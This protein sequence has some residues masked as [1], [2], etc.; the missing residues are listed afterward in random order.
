MNRTSLFF[1]SV[2]LTLEGCALAE[3]NRC[4]TARPSIILPDQRLALAHIN[5]GSAGRELAEAVFAGNVDA[6]RR[7]IAADPRL[8]SSSVKFDPKMQSPP[9]GQYGDLLTF[10]VARCDM[11]MVAALLAAGMPPDGVQKG[12]ALT[13][14]LLA[15]TPD[16]ADTLLRAGASP[17][18]QKQGGKNAMHELIAFGAIGGVETLIR[19]KA[20][21][22]YV[23]D[24]G[25]DH[26]DTALSMEQ[27]AI[28]E[29]LVKAGGKLWR[30]NGAGALSAWTLNKP[31]VLDPAK[32]DMK[33]RQRLIAQAQDSGLPWP[34]PDPAMIRK[35]VLAGSWPT[36]DMEK[37]GMVLSA[38]A[39]ADIV[40]RFGRH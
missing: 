19:H 12:E 1:L 26:L 15:D 23:D 35:M 13:L 8:L 34:P 20:D 31:P 37:A 4:F 36:P 5:T 40:K 30:I 14:A 39:K 11:D 22:N 17:D 16:I 32:S 28:A 6:V 29:R 2:F 33:A 7:L 18:P 38:E 24:F 27:Y 9:P 21:M 3:D 10:A 25:N